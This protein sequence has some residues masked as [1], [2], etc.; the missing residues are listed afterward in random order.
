M[1]E[2]RFE[3]LAPLAGLGAV[4]FM[5]AGAGVFGV[6]DY[7]PSA[8]KLTDIFSD[9]PSRVLLAGY[10][11]LFSAFFLIWF[12]GSLFSSLSEQEGG[13]GRLSMTAFGGGIASGIAMGIG[14][15]AMVSV[16]ARAGAVGGISAAEAVTQYDTYST[17]L[18]Q[19]TAFTLAVLIG[20]S[21][22]IFLRTSMVKGWIGWASVLIAIGLLSPFGYAVL[23]FA[24]VWLVW[25]SFWLYRQG[26]STS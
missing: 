2:S 11:G 14:F 15:S 23:A 24:L 20:A 9:N 22:L 4:I 3:K 5:M 6:Y 26:A 8:E 16:G 21:G 10:L 19:M 25:M 1:N 18:G 12:S 13:N 17:I 7:L